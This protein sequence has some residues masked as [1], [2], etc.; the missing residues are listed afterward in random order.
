[1]PSATPVCFTGMSRNKGIDMNVTQFAIRTTRTWLS[2]LA[3]LTILLACASQGDTASDSGT[4]KNSAASTG[5][6][7]TTNT[8]IEATAETDAAAE[9]EDPY[10]DLVCRKI[11]P[12]GSRV[13]ESICMRPE[14]CEKY[15]DQGRRDLE[16]AQRIALTGNGSGG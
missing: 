2:S 14:Q 13:S 7:T 11:Q 6:E 9:V 12:T 4:I 3:F 15:A 16:N 1:M 8:D 5:A 10:K